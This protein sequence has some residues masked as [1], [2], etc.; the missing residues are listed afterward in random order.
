MT[1]LGIR[2]HQSRGREVIELLL[3][4]GN[5]IDPIYDSWPWKDLD[6]YSDSDMVYILDP[7]KRKIITYY[8]EDTFNKFSLGEINIY[9]L[10]QFERIFP[11]KIGDNVALK[12]PYTTGKITDMRWEKESGFV[13]YKYSGDNSQRWYKYTAFAFA[14]IDN[15]KEKDN[16]TE[17]EKLAQ[18]FLDGVLVAKD[19]L[20]GSAKSW[21]RKNFKTYCK[22][23]SQLDEDKFINDFINYLTESI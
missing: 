18:I 17:D 12:H 9:D 1:L 3:Q 6:T 7:E 13:I 15:F 21:M 20:L 8:Y 4:L 22:N 19:N 10:E 16:L 2:G 11:Y 23:I 14:S 5:I